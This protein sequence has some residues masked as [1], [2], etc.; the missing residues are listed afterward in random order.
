MSLDDES[1]EIY[2][3]DVGQDSREE[4]TVARRGGNHQ[5]PYKEG[6]IAGPRKKP[7]K[8][9]GR[10]VPPVF[11]YPRSMGGCVIGGMVYRGSAHTGT[12]TCAPM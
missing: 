1:G 9:I 7:A 11:D 2:V 3:A 4:I 8:I 6:N 10:E 5:W 12:L